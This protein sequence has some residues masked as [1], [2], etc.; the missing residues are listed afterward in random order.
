MSFAA[1]KMRS[2]LRSRTYPQVKNISMPNWCG[3]VFIIQLFIV[4]TYAS[5][6]KLYPDWLNANVTGLLMSDKANYFLIGEL[7]QKKWLHYF[8]A[9]GGILFD[10]LII[11]LLLFK[12][13]R[14]WAFVISIFFHLFNSI[15]LAG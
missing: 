1:T 3:L 8:L 9:Y 15:V 5:A 12:S 10:G 2:I 14:K 13:T 11:P 7:L 4:Y 6:A